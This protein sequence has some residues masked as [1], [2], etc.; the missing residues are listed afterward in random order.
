M[1]LEVLVGDEDPVVY[2]LTNPKMT[3]GSSE[4]CDIV[5]DTDGVSRKHVGILSEDDQY[6]VVDLG[7]TNGSFINEERLIPGKRVEFTSFFPVRLGQNVL[8]SLLSDEESSDSDEK[9]EIP[10]SFKEPV[11]EEPKKLIEPSE[12]TTVIPL[13][14]LNNVKTEKL[15]LTRNEKRAVKKKVEKPKTKK[16]KNYFPYLALFIFIA[17]AAYNILSLKDEDALEESTAEIGKITT[18]TDNKVNSKDSE[19]TLESVSTDATHSRL[20]PEEELAN[21]DSYYQRLNELKCASDLEIRLCN[22]FPQA[23]GNVF[24]V[25]QAG[26]S[27]HIMVNAEAYYS[28]AKSIVRAPVMNSVEALKKYEDLV[29]DTTAYLYLLRSLQHGRLDA[30]S[31]EDFKFFIALFL[32]EGEA[33]PKLLKVIAIRPDALIELKG[34][35]SDQHLDIIKATGEA[36]FSEVNSFYRTY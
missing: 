23:R 19:T 21:K 4:H 7:S 26:L 1:R 2:Q 25:V 18:A 24:G 14:E 28:H 35:L 12:K 29:Y 22:F 15:I 27:L 3:V 33:S 10:S 32:V 31:F 34:L 16:K 13:R 20:I 11:K 5:I 30:S 17:G 9:I 36:A 6:F 8:L